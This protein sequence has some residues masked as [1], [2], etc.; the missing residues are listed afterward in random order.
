M[1]LW[2]S[3]HFPFITAL[4]VT[5]QLIILLARDITCDTVWQNIASAREHTLKPSYYKMGWRPEQNCIEFIQIRWYIKQR[6]VRPLLQII[7]TEQRADTRRRGCRTSL[8]QLIRIPVNYA[9]NGL[10]LIWTHPL[11]A[12][13]GY[14]KAKTMK[15]NVWTYKKALC[16]DETS[17]R[18]RYISVM[19]STVTPMA[20]ASEESSLSVSVKRFTVL[21]RCRENSSHRFGNPEIMIS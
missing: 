20:Q 4:I 13:R 10:W 15:Y 6:S 3:Q 16:N 14:C 1:L 2:P 19:V 11:A 8:D 12:E 9:A 17:L 21:L 7:S 5:F 18:P